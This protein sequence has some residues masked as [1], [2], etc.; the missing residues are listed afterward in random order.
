MAAETSDENIFS[1]IGI[2]DENK[3]N[4]L[5]NKQNKLFNHQ[6]NYNKNESVKR[7]KFILKLYSLWINNKIQNKNKNNDDNMNMNMYDIINKLDKSYNFNIFLSDYNYIV[8]NE[9]LLFDND[10][11]SDD[12][13]ICDASSCL[14]ISR[15][16]RNKSLY[17]R[18]DVERN[19]LYFNND[20]NNNSDDLNR[21]ILSQQIIDS[22]HDTFYHTLRINKNEYINNNNNDD[23][24]K[25]DDDDDIDFD[26]EIEKLCKIIEKR[27]KSSKRFIRSNNRYSTYN[28]FITTDSTETADTSITN[29]N[30]DNNKKAATS[31]TQNESDDIAVY[32]SVVYGNESLLLAK[33]GIKY[34]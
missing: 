6:N 2:S 14:M 28:K 29:N 8:N 25:I 23:D 17:S 5:I 13:N 26:V 31:K 9:N 4:N 7:I 16:N 33:E 22:L 20:N 15:V 12:N 21:N 34:N 30:D 24:D 19:K 10:D 11:D 1:S 3:K 27:K 32:Q 18:N